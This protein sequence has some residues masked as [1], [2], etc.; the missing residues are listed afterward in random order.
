MSYIKGFPG[1]WKTP[2]AIGSTF[3][4]F[5]LDETKVNPKPTAYG[6][7]S[8]Y[9]GSITVT[10][11][12]G[13]KKFEFDDYG[14]IKGDKIFTVS[15]GEN[16]IYY[17]ITLA[18]FTIVKPEG[19]I[20]PSYMHEYSTIIVV[21]VQNR[22]PLKPWTNEEV[23]NRVLQLAEPLKEGESPR[24]SLDKENSGVTEKQ[25]SA[26][27]PEF[28]F[29]RMNLR[30]IMQTVGGVLHGEPRLHLNDDY[31]GRW[32]YDK[33]GGNTLAT[34]KN[35]ATGEI[36]P[37][38][39]WRYT[40]NRQNQDIE[41][42]CTKID[43]YQD[44]LVNRINWQDG[45]ISNPSEYL[46]RG[47]TLRSETLYIRLSEEDTGAYFNTEF[48]IDK[49][50]RFEVVYRTTNE[51]SGSITTNT[52]DI[53]PYVF[54]SAVYENLSSY[55]GGYP[56]SKSYALYYE[57]GQKGIKGF[58]FKPP[59]GFGG[60]IG[61]DYSIVNILKS[62]SVPKSVYSNYDTIE[63]RI[64]YVPIYSTR[65]QHSKVYLSDHLAAGRTINYS[66]GDNSVETR[67]FG[68]NIKGAVQRLGTVEKYVSF[69]F[70]YAENI[71]KAGDLWDDEYY[72]STV[73]VA[74]FSDRFE[75]T[76]GLSKHFNR[77]SKYIGA[78]SHKRIYEVS[79]TM[80]QERHTVVSDYM[81]IEP[82]DSEYASKDFGKLY[83]SDVGFLYYWSILSSSTIRYK[84][85]EFTFMGYNKKREKIKENTISLPCIASA[86]GNSVEFTA[87]CAD[88][89]SAGAKVEKYTV[90]DISGYFTQGV[91]YGD[92][93]GRLYY[94]AWNIGLG[95]IDDNEEQT[96]EKWAQEALSYPE[97]VYKRTIK[98]TIATT[99][100]DSDD[101]AKY[102]LYRKD[103]REKLKFS[104]RIEAVAGDKSFIIGT[105]LSVYNPVVTS[106][107]RRDK[108]GRPV[109]P[110]IYILRE[111][112]GKFD[113]LFDKDAIVSEY[114]MSPYT[115]REL[116]LYV[117][118][119]TATES[120]K[121]WVIAYPYYD[122]ETVK[123]ENEDG[124]VEDYTPKYG[125][126]IIIGRNIPISA[127]DKVGQFVAYAVHDL[128]A[129]IDERRKSG[130]IEI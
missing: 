3:T 82:S 71:P 91:E 5:D 16:K 40:T 52:K 108:S 41:Q 50:E 120:G 76:C 126:E 27:S 37:L 14:K 119:V 99:G 19:I 127:G 54:P 32:T 118:G 34:Y 73:N 57:H 60:T 45:T 113:T 123:L 21:G 115:G 88:N 6:D 8:Y 30:E 109:S 61:K 107:V 38:N 92:Y 48:P 75:I 72:I 23:I 87:E 65:I 59:S 106:V 55:S 94:L 122:G 101:N 33:Y 83:I 35:F 62:V 31:T 63:F 39:T 117:Y 24:F 78:N 4:L 98:Y 80:V 25:F 121:A 28:T 64:E 26:L 58:F 43:S 18:T 10:N 13:E 130:K 77:K 51:E 67:F 100:F 22:Y 7:Y 44:N 36:K 103:S 104:Y 29:T 124:E 2:T 69:N 128:Q 95:W 79:E 56:S 96:E 9:E 74:V 112:I 49:I 81:V 111:E 12:D 20:F 84:A 85:C 102:L 53:T 46:S 42:A 97:D 70:K 93:Y 114:D 66:Q 86:F 129:Y 89:F 11:S 1:N 125:G 110:K 17:N 47:I 90:G 116:Y 15:M 105:G 68:E